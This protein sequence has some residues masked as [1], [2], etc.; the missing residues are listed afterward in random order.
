MNER[1]IELPL[2]KGKPKEKYI[3]LS[4]GIGALVLLML[5][6]IASFAFTI[7]RTIKLHYSERS[8][9]DYK[10]YLKP[11]DYYNEKYLG[12]NK[13]YVAS[14]ID[15]I[16]TDFDYTFKSDDKLDLNY[17]Y[18]VVA[19]VEVNDGQNKNIY[20]KEEIIKPKQTPDATNQTIKI[21][22][23]VVVDYDKY[24]K[25]ASS[26]IDQYKLTANAKLTVSLM[27]DI[28]GKHSKFDNK[29]TNKEVVSYKIPLTEK[30]VDVE[31]D[32]K[33]SNDADQ[34][35]QHKQA[36]VNNK[37][38]LTFIIVLMVVDVLAIIYVVYW[39]IVN[40]DNETKYIKKLEKIKRDYSRYIS[41][42]IIT[43]RVEDMM[44]TR[45]LRIEVIKKFEDLLDI[46]DSLNKPILFHE[47]RPNEE[48][49]FYI[50][51]DRIGYLYIMRADDFKDEKKKKHDNV[52]NKMINSKKK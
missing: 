17:S 50:L 9:I 32:Y 10:V 11:N 46:R 6:L 21:H 16:N 49:V 2:L 8:N 51:T 13:K 34:V 23:N 27:I 1:N 29:L 26:F 3:P 4:V 43:E 35:I 5:L 22:E 30:T 25:I 18:Y 48:A 38:L 33:L 14:L 31:M 19:K 44:L 40:R 45:S 24:N 15:N 28:E 37:F 47:E 12:K 42:T 39:V 20:T 36:F 52:I 41:E 7:K